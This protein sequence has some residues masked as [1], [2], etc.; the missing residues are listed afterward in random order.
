MKKIIIAA[1]IVLTSG[2][3]ALSITRNTNKIE[4]VKA[5]SEKANL[6]AKTFTGGTNAS[7]TL[8]TAD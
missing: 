8:A 1:A 7:V 2:V 6:A 5:N 4:E 3:T